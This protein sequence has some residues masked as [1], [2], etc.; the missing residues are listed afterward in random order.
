MASSGVNAFNRKSIKVHFP[1]HES[2]IVG[3]TKDKEIKRNNGYNRNNSNYLAN[4]ASD[5]FISIHLTPFTGPQCP[6]IV[7]L[8]VP[9]NFHMCNVLS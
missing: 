3:D 8:C 4:V 9:S 6:G 5:S 7:D 1:K 2:L